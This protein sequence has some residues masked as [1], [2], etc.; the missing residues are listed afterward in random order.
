MSVNPEKKFTGTA[1]VARIKDPNNSLSIHK[2][3]DF[4]HA[5]AYDDPKE[6]FDYMQLKS[7][8][9]A[10]NKLILY[11]YT[12]NKRDRTSFTWKQCLDALAVNKPTGDVC[13]IH[14]EEPLFFG[15]LAKLAYE[16]HILHDS[17]GYNELLVSLDPT[18]LTKLPAPCPATSRSLDTS[19]S[20]LD[21]V[22]L[23][24]RQAQRENF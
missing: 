17:N 4:L 20:D 18:P 11:S 8:V 12:I 13:I 15:R 9:E 3:P 22:N 16:H 24:I 5:I 10:K 21:A 2:K 23:G 1:Y 7:L 14:Y 19:R 6:P